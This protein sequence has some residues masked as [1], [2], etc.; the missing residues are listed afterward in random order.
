M[1]LKTTYNCESIIL[2]YKLGV[3]QEPGGFFYVVVDCRCDLP[4]EKAYLLRLQLLQRPLIPQHQ[5][6]LL[7]Q[8]H[9]DCLF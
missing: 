5:D 8:I 7:I 6:I 4:L 1:H 2:P 9:S 3:A